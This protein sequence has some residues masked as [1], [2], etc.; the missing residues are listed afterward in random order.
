MG[1][2]ADVF[3]LLDDLE[4]RA[5]AA[6]AAERAAEVRDRGRAEY[7]A[8]TLA[9][10]LMA[11]LGHQVGLDVSGVGP[12][13]G[14]LDRLGD[15]WCLVSSPGPAGSHDWVVP[16]VAVSS[17]RGVSERAVPEVA[18]PPVARL[19]LGSALRRL[20]EAGA[21]CVLHLRDG[22]RLEGAVHRVGRDF[23]EVALGAEDPG[24]SLCLVPFAALGAVQSR[25]GPPH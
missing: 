21:G 15:G 4:Q 14:R 2:D 9:G 7:A 24:G 25:E 10:R 5:E 20:A 3:A 17:V 23:A 19:G 12:V 6:F 1:W 18:W 8:V 11:S 16:L 13:R 22:T